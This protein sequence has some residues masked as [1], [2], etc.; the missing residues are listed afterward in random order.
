M[1]PFALFAAA[2]DSSS[3]EAPPPPP[4]VVITVDNALQVT[5]VAIQA[6]F[7]LAELGDVIGGLLEQDLGAMPAGLAVEQIAAQRLEAMLA[8]QA[9]LPA[10]LS[11]T[12]PGPEGG[13]VIQ[14]WDDRDSDELISA[15]DSFVSAF[16]DYGE[17]GLVL[18]GVVTF[19]VEDTIGLP[20]DGQTWTVTGP[21]TF[22]NLTVASGADSVLLA[23]SVRY[24][25]ERRATVTLSNLRL[26]APLTFGDQVLQPGNETGYDS[27]PATFQ[28]ALTG[29]GAV[30]AAGLDGQIRFETKVVFTGL[31]FFGYPWGGELEIRGAD[32][33]K[34]TAR[35]VDF[36]ST[37]EI[38]V[39]VD[40]DGDTD[41]TLTADWNS[42]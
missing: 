8:W 17:D 31:T 5:T 25:R 38:L 28:F 21:M 22:M 12:L 39:D 1:L 23:G 2:C 13:E 3:D 26:E 10:T 42:L 36:T 24:T 9:L 33:S 7:G 6:A 18:N 11:A 27:Y 32:D 15:G 16:T 37:I 35:M 14:T 34:I 4:G 30:E 20:P 41:E 29:A 19:D 40:G